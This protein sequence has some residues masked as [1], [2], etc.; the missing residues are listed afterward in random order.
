M[1]KWLLVSGVLLPT[2]D[3]LAQSNHLPGQLLSASVRQVGTRTRPLHVQAIVVTGKVTDEKGAGLPG[4][5]VSLKGTNIGTNTDAQGNYSIRVPD[6]NEGGSL[7]ISFV[8]YAAQE[9]PIGSKTVIN[10]QLSADDK[11]LNE[12]VV[13]G[14]GTQRK[15]EISGA[16]SVIT[17]KEIAQNPSPNLSNALVGQTA[18]IIATQRSGEPGNDASNIY[19]RGIG[20][21]GD[22]SPIYVIDGI[23]RSSSDFAQ[24]NS[25]EI[26]SFSILKDAAS[27]AVFGVR[28][29]NGV[30]L[31]TTKRGASGKTQFSY[32]ANFGIQQRTRT[33]EYLNSYDYATLYNEALANDGKPAQFS[34]SDLQKYK[35]HSDPDRYP[36]SDWFNTLLKKTAPVTQHNLS[37]NGGTEKVRYAVSL[38]YLNQDGVVPNNNFK[39]YNFR[40]NIDADLTKTTRLA[41]DLAGRNEKTTT[42][43]TSFGTIFQKLTAFPPTRFPTQYSNGFY[44]NSPAYL[45]I[46][47]NGYS[48]RGVYAFRGRMQLLQ[49]IPFVPGLSIKAIGSFD[50]TLTDTKVW[51]NPVVPYYSILPDGTF[52]QQPLAPSSLSQDHYDDQAITLETHLNYEK[53][54]GKNKVTGLV[55]YTQTRQDWNDLN[56]YREKFTIG[57]DELNFGPA[58]NRNNGGYSGSSG[59]QG[60][61]GRINF[62]HNEKYTLETSFRADGSEQFAP[63]RRWGFFPSVS[64]AWVVSEESFLKNV[65]AID[66]LKLRGSYGVLGN[67]RIGGARFLYLQSYFAAGN[68]VFGDGSVQQAIAEGNL[69]YPNVTWETVKKLDLGFD[70]TLLKGKINLTFDYFYDKR[71]DVL[72]YRNAS[73]PALLGIGLPVENIA[74]VNNHG[75][76]LTIGHA[77]TINRSL[78]Y[79][80]SANVTY[81]RNKIIFI[82][83]PATTNPNLMRTGRPLYTEFGFRALGLFQTQAEVDAAPKQ[84]GKTAPGDIRYEDV[85]GDGKVD[86][87]DRVPIGRANVPEIIFGYN[88]KVNY[89]N[90]EL[91][92]LFQGATNVN[93]WYRGE[94]AWPFFVGAG[95]LKQNLDRWTPNNPGASEPRVLVSPTNMNQYNNSSFWLRDGSYLR[96]KSVELA[97]NLPQNFLGLSFIQGL[98]VYVNANNVVTWTKIKNFDPE[99]QSDRGWGYPQLRI[100]NA[101]FNIQF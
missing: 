71:S 59:R 17:P 53:Q 8:G 85:N 57:V 94:A 44:T 48:R 32:S 64:G 9:F 83:E 95:A 73:V 97:Y 67:D 60:V 74:K 43:P 39:R 87:N 99:N 76:E 45:F 50:K 37:V 2:P 6:G 81:A 58:L 66:Y 47:E 36:D 86:D 92:F 61:V 14:Y 10:A 89:R 30:I 91:A 34:A 88:A 49:Q 40:S 72:G 26:Q 69:S 25:S 11:S 55:L 98:R 54:F 62:S 42:P 65:N 84:I 52:Q 31:V 70:A 33:P 1:I 90:F 20:T 22:A 51:N 7:V 15:S 80:M 27:A 24:L 75:V 79:N 5:S 12:V 13:V 16:V 23:V 82:D 18:G 41:F 68:A 46:P 100:F 28:A 63:G 29:G 38:S 35:D 56:A 96:L 77:N 3:L 19:I 21:T 78:R 4:A 101:G 93:Q